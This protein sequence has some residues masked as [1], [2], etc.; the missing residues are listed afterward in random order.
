MLF[1]TFVFNMS[2]N[3]FAPSD[4]PNQF[5]CIVMGNIDDVSNKKI[6]QELA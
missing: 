2:T 4:F 3:L 1:A 6:C 5:F